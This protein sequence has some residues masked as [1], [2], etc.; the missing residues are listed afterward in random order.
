MLFLIPGL[1]PWGLGLP[2]FLLAGLGLANTIWQQRRARTRQMNRRSN[3]LASR[4]TIPILGLL[5]LAVF[6]ILV[7]G[8]TTVGPY[9]LV[10]V[11]IVLLA[12]AASNAAWILLARMDDSE[13]PAQR[14][15]S[16]L[17]HDAE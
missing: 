3:D 2:L 1:S 16:G 11:I 5:G 4:F 14:S 10:F 15:I 13:V 9:G 7:M 12:S 6:A 17:Q 8:Q